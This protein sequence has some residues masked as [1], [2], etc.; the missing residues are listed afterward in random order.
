MRDPRL[1]PQ[2]GDVLKRKRLMRKV[3]QIEKGRV[4]YTFPDGTNPREC[5]LATWQ[6]WAANAEVVARGDES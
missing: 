6:A 2:K 1:E 3:T 5:Y 4:F